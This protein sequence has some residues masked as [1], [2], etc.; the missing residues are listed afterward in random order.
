MLFPVKLLDFLSPPPLPGSHLLSCSGVGRAKHHSPGAER[1]FCCATAGGCRGAGP[2]LAGVNRSQP[3][4]VLGW[5][6]RS[7]CPQPP[8]RPSHEQ[9]K[10]AGHTAG[11]WE[12]Q[13]WAKVQ[14]LCP[15]PAAAPAYC[16]SPPLLLWQSHCITLA[17][18]K[19]EC[20]AEQGCTRKAVAFALSCFVVAEP[21]L[22]LAN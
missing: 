7:G 2:P 19:A 11:K 15:G 20:R 21:R 8:S 17:R 6:W 1:L 3:L 13:R 22:A 12:A 9:R 16:Q 14:R 5:S 18:G 4:A 10:Q